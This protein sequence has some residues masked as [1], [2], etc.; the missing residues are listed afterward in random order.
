MYRRA[1]D[2]V[3]FVSQGALDS[4]CRRLGLP[5][6]LATVIYNPVVDDEL[7][8]ASQEPVDH[9]WFAEGRERPIILGVGR[10]TKQ[11]G[12]PYLLRAFRRV[13]SNVPARLVVVGDGE[14][15]QSLTSLASKLD[16]ERD[17]AF[18]GFQ[19]NPYKFMARADAFVLPSLWE[20]FGLVLVEAMA[21][22]APVVATR[23]RS[24]PEEIVSDGASG[25][26]VPPG[27]AN[28]LSDAILNLLTSPP[29]ARRLST[30]GRRRAEDFRVETS[31]RQYEQLF[32]SV[33]ARRGTQVNSRTPIRE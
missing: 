15:R 10:L 18:V 29:L 24:G 28:A 19:R 1:A 30:A 9:A 8:E 11:K 20:G 6:D 2:K 23:C 16:V 7:L 12:F 21:C 3:V 32:R 22:G 5:K 33:L 27:D 14:D 25:L 4:G 17:V 26:L 13:R 31:A